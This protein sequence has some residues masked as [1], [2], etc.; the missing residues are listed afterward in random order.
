[1]SSGSSGTRSPSWPTLQGGCDH[2]PDAAAV[3]DRDRD[4]GPH[5][6]GL[7]SATGPPSHRA[8]ARAAGDRRRPCGAQR[9]R[10]GAEPWAVGARR[11]TSQDGHSR[12]TSSGR[13]E[14]P[15]S[16]GSRDSS[17]GATAWVTLPTSSRRARPR[18]RRDR[19]SSTQVARRDP[20]SGDDRAGVRRAR[21]SRHVGARRDHDGSGRAPSTRSGRH[22]CRRGRPR[23]IGC[24]TDRRGR[25]VHRHLRRCR[26]HRSGAARGA[27]ER[28]AGT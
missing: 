3:P 24:V 4:P 8:T 7:Q 9:F 27:R 21:R 23:C 19:S 5:L 26:G 10:P 22:A 14:R 16:A 1:M 2:G 18:C 28:P 15:G 11:S 25:L 17:R 6:R 20:Q 12:Y 13:G